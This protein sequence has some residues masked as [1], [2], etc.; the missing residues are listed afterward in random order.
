MHR[1]HAAVVGAALIITPL[2]SGLGAQSK[3][4]PRPRLVE[5]A[6]TNDAKAYYDLGVALLERDPKK[7]ADA[8]YWSIRLNPAVAEAYY[9]RRI[10]LHLSEP[11]R[12][13]R[14]WVGDRSTL[15]NAEVQRI[16]SLHLRALTL[17]PFLYQKHD[18]LLL[19]SIIKQVATDFVGASGNSLEL[20]HEIEGYLMNAPAAT[21]AWYAYGEGRFEEALRLYAQAI[22]S[23]K[24]KA[25]LRADR[26]RLFF[27]I[28]QVDSALAELTLAV[29]E[30]RKSDKK[31]L[32]FV[33][34]S[35]ALLEHS[36]AL[37]H[38][39]LG[40]NDAAREALGRALQEDLSY[41]PAHQQLSFMALEAKDTA[42]AISELDL[43]VQIRGDDEALRFD[44]G[45][46]LSALGKLPEAEEQL[47]KA[48]ALNPYFASPHLTR[49]RVLAGLR[50]E[51]EAAAEL[52]TFLSL[53]PRTDTRRKEAEEWLAQLEASAK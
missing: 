39:R 18:R 28:G 51:P 17:N 10:A 3:V 26:G 47:R 46:I 41:A 38:F 27:Q 44:Y 13:R 16:D 35:K 11:A 23:A 9:A 20:E 36:V 15:K 1:M 43:A 21:R 8:L 40:N 49:A 7:A 53:A 48:I 29:E 25:G 4:P 33:Y 52:R 5:D 50:R 30:M 22:K 45:Y 34:D 14:Y 24:R 42:T 19:R 32:V 2:L 6:D 31:D 37:A 12:L